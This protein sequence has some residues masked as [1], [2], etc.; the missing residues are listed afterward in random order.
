MGGFR[1]LK[2]FIVII[3]KVRTL[4]PFLVSRLV[5]LGRLVL[6]NSFLPMSHLILVRNIILVAKLSLL[7]IRKSR[8]VLRC[9]T[10]RL[11]L[12]NSLPVVFF[13]L[14]LL[15]IWVRLMRPVIRLLKLLRLRLGVIKWGSPF[16]ML[17]VD[18]VR[19]VVVRVRTQLKRILRL[20]LTRSVRRVKA[21]VIIVKFRKLFIRVKILL[22]RRIRSLK[23]F[24]RPPKILFRLLVVRKLR[25]MRVRVIPVPVKLFLFLLVVKFNGRNLFLNRFVVLLEKF[26]TR[27]MNLLWGRFLMTLINLLMRRNV[28]QIKV[29][30]RRRPNIILMQLVVLIGLLILV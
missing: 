10:R 12:I 1:F 15:F 17:R 26:L 20:T 6:V 4:R 22:M 30:W 14:I 23:K 13:V 3:Q 7:K 11:L 2:T 29:I 21:F 16:L 8:M 5:P 25:Q 27:L 18:V 28:R 19:F 24:R 9:R